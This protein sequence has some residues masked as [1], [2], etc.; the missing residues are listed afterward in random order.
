MS[1]QFA[2]CAA[3]PHRLSV[4]KDAIIAL[5]RAIS[6]DHGADGI[7]ANCVAPGPVY[8]PM[9]YGRGMTEQARETH[10][11]ASVLKRE[12][13]SW[14]IGG[15]VRFLLSEKACNITGQVLVVEGGA[16]LVGPSRASQ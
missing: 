3:R 13:T 4:S 2:R 5:T 16:T 10:R 12:G 7:R 6:V 14:D 9:V 8:T 15:A 11:Q 1:L